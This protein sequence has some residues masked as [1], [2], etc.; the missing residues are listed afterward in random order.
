MSASH[1][2]PE[3]P[4]ETWIGRELAALLASMPSGWDTGPLGRATPSEAKR[5][6]WAWSREGVLRWR[7]RPDVHDLESSYSLRV[8]LE[9]HALFLTHSS[10]FGG[11]LLLPRRMIRLGSLVPFVALADPELRAHLRAEDPEERVIAQ[12]LHRTALPFRTAL[13][14]LLVTHHP[15]FD[16]LT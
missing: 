2:P 7:I 14:E 8:L 15:D 16:S 10:S 6:A 5:D 3:T 9:T 4:L 12:L 13:Q 1:L 11:E